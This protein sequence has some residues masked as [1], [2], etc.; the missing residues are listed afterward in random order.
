MSQL[1]STKSHQGLGSRNKRKPDQRY[2]DKISKINSDGLVSEKDTK[3]FDFN[4]HSK[5][6]QQI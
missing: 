5:A 6:K 4:P 1:A 2:E 3:L